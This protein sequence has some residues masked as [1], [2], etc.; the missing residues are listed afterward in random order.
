MGGTPSCDSLHE[1]PIRA[2][3]FTKHEPTDIDVA[4]GD[5]A[6]SEKDVSFRPIIEEEINRFLGSN[7]A[8]DTTK[9]TA[10]ES[11]ILSKNTESMDIGAGCIG[12]TNAV[13]DTT[14]TAEKFTHRR[15]SSLIGCTIA[16]ILIVVVAILIWRYFVYR[17]GMRDQRYG[18]SDRTTAFP[19]DGPEK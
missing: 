13:K 9:I 2:C 3:N 1:C 14:K 4:T 6:D 8:A 5:Y 18:L 10:L 15:S 17:N 19:L 16:C 12:F 7:E 11:A